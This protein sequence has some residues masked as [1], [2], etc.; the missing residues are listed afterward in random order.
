[1]AQSHYQSLPELPY[2]RK[3]GKWINT[4]FLSELPRGSKIVVADIMASGERNE[5]PTNAQRKEMKI[6]V[7]T[8]EQHMY[9]PD[10][11]RI[12]DLPEPHDD[13][14]SKK[15]YILDTVPEDHSAK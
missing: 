15:K 2:R 1:M 6:V 13:V 11:A 4:M 14:V 10:Y 8:I 9:M 7:E 3:G 12:S 5:L